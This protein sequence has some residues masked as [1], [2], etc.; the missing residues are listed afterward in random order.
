MKSVFIFGLVFS[1]A[2]LVGPAHALEPFVPYDNFN[3]IF[4]DPDK[5]IGQEP[6]TGVLI[7]ENSRENFLGHVHFRSRVYT[8]SD[9]GGGFGGSR[10]I[11][12]EAGKVTAIKAKVQVIY[13][14]AKGCATDPTNNYTRAAVRLGGFFFNTGPPPTTAGNAVNDVFAGVSVQRLS[15]STDKPQVLKV[16]GSVAKCL[17][18]NCTSSTP[19]YSVDLGTTSLWSTVSVSIQWDKDNHQFIFAL[20][21]YPKTYFPYNILTYPDTLPPGLIQ[22]RIE[23]Q[24]LLPNCTGEPQPVAFIDAFLDDVFVNQGAAP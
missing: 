2:L 9:G 4:L 12:A 19:I 3:T 6:N 8:D 13:V 21:G 16:V 11:F 18:S 24:G 20:D 14:E 7:L 1:L 17:N 5:W 15:N 22:K 10:L 23:V